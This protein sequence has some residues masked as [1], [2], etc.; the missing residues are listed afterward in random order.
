MAELNK[1]MQKML[2][3]GSC[4]FGMRHHASGGRVDDIGISCV[5]NEAA[6]RFLPRNAFKRSACDSFTMI[7][8]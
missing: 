2:H 3:H 5:C 1:I 6:R 7:H 8:P 4:I